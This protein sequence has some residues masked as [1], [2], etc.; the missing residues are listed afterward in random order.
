MVVSASHDSNLKLYRWREGQA[1]V[2]RTVSARTITIAGVVSPSTCTIILAC[3]DNTVM[4][5]GMVTGAWR[6]TVVAHT[7]A[8]SCIGWGKGVLATGSWDGLVKLWACVSTNSYTVRMTDLTGEL[9]HASPVTCLDLQME[10]E[11][12]GTIATGTREGEVV[13]WSVLSGRGSMAH[14]LPSHSRQV[15]CVALAPGGDRI[16]S[17]GSDMGI[18]VFDLK[19]GTVVFS[20]NV[21]EEVVCLAWDGVLALVGGGRGELSVWD[22]GRG[23]REPESRTRGHVGR[24]TAMAVGREEGKMIVVTGGEDKRV[25]VW[26]PQLA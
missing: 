20:K 18:K 3:W 16:L 4:V 23:R 1:G 24:V 6:S 7:D 8:V 21:G 5:Y 2:E 25:I 26:R 22:L 9:D 15:N 14:K 11:G 17:G 10:G 12:V 13:V 19:T